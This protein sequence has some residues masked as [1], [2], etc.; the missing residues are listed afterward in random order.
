MD[1]CG[2]WYLWSFTYSITK[3]KKIGR[4]RRHFKKNKWR[5]SYKIRSIIVNIKLCCKIRRRLWKSCL[6]KKRI[7]IKNKRMSRI[8]SQSWK[9]NFW[10]GRWKNILENKRYWKKKRYENCYRGFY[11]MCMLYFIFWCTKPIN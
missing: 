6:R 8:I 11:I 7:I 9:I 5:I 4:S 3:K 10:F 1:S 2:S